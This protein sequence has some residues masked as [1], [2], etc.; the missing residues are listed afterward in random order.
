MRIT[1]QRS[2]DA[3]VPESRGIVVYNGHEVL[4][5]KRRA[6]KTPDEEE[7]DLRPIPESST[8]KGSR[9]RPGTIKGSAIGRFD[10][11]GSTE[12]SLRLS[13]TYGSPEAVLQWRMLSLRN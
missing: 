1:D 10:E 6:W 3:D 8:Q 5:P 11:L 4:G 13:L 2:S 12:Q 7:D 9:T